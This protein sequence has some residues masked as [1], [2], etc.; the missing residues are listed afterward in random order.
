M[1]P[2]LVLRVLFLRSLTVHHYRKYLIDVLIFEPHLP[3]NG[4]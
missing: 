2:P 3:S 1:A 4:M